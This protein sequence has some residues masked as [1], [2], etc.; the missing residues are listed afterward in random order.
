MP[1]PILREYWTGNRAFWLVDFSYWP[2]DCLSRVINQYS[3]MTSSL[4]GQTSM[5]GVVFFVSKSLLK[6]EGQKHHEEF[7]IL[8]R[9][10]RTHARILIYW[11]WPLRQR[12]E[13][14]GSRF[15]FNVQLTNWETSYKQ[16]PI[17]DIF[18]RR[19]QNVKKFLIII[20]PHIQWE[21]QN[22]F[23]SYSRTSIKQPL[24]VPMRAVQLFLPLLCSQPPF[25]RPLPNSLRVAV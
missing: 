15:V 9:E 20:A 24:L 18:T 12:K 5:F 17:N 14:M 3:N 1:G 13:R 25:K 16:S 23:S 8:T 10:P 6:I 7:A 4:S 11:T 21:K 19:R 22:Q 2:S